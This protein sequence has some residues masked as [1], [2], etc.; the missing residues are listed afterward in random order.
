MCGYIN[1][2]IIIFIYIT[3]TDSH[4]FPKLPKTFER[5]GVNWEMDSDSKKLSYVKT[6][7]SLLI[8]IVNNRTMPYDYDN[9]YDDKKKDMEKEDKELDEGIELGL[10]NLYY[11]YYYFLVLIFHF[12]YIIIFYIYYCY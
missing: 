10:E 12:I 1:K 2:Q 6:V 8:A 3:P 7:I 5:V 11:Y 9:N 4:S